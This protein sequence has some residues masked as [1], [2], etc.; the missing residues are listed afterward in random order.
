MGKR[1]KIFTSVAV[2]AVFLSANPA[3]AQQ[4][5]P[6]YNTTLYSDSTHSTVVGHIVWTGCDRWNYP[7]YDLIGT[8]SYH[9]V[10]EP[11]GYCVDGQMTPL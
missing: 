4:G 11:V 1:S 9:G 7:Q 5:T 3:S 10:D 6:A 8:Y 2:A